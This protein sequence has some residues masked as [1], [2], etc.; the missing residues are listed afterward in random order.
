[1]PTVSIS[2]ESSCLII[3]TVIGFITFV[4]LNFG[5]LLIC[6]VFII[7]WMFVGVCCAGIKITAKVST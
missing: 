1:M 5:R 3:V 4:R 7:W 2:H 6:A